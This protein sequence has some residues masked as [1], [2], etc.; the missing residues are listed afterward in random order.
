MFIIALGHSVEVL[1]LDAPD[2]PFVKECPLT[3]HAM[4]TGQGN[5]G[6]SKK[7]KPWLSAHAQ[8]YDVF[9]INGLWQYHSFASHSV[10]KGQNRPYYVFTHGMLDPWFKHQ[11][12]LKHLKKWFYWPWGEYPVLRDA[13]KVLFT[14][15]DEKISG[16]AIVLAVS[17]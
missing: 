10:L 8:N 3:V 11:Y 16:A 1:S 7:F 17:L 2:V 4:G 14:C 12:P 6:Y 15:E 5:Y 9:I 13:K